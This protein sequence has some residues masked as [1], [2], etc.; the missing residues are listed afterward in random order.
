MLL[1]DCIERLQPL[2]GNHWDTVQS[3]YNT[4]SEPSW[5]ARDSDS[6]RRKFKTLKNVRK[7]TGDPDCPVEV[8]RAKRINRLIESRMAVVDMES[9][10][11]SEHA[12][13]DDDDDET[14]PTPEQVP[15]PVL[16]TPRTGLDPTQLSALAGTTGS[17]MA[18]QTAQRRRRIDEILSESAENEAIKRRLIFESRD[19]RQAMLEAMIAMEERQ[20]VREQESRLLRERLAEEREERVRLREDARIARQELLDAQREERQAK[21]DQVMLVLM[22]KFLEK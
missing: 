5:I 6:I 9:D 22:S 19:S 8:V 7:P 3:Q 21:M 11:D 18:S 12:P 16:A 17:T 20:S 10:K 14:P 1:L 15:T 13:I 2:G 4:L